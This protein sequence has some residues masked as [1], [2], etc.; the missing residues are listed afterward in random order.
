MIVFLD[1]FMI[2]GLG[3]WLRRA[4]NILFLDSPFLREGV[5]AL[6][7]LIAPENRTVMLSC[8]HFGNGRTRLPH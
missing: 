6:L 4:L 3:T 2:V 5:V 8:G 7:A 1:S